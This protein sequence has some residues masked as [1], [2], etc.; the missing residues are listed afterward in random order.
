MA[1]EMKQSVP[2][3]NESKKAKKEQLRQIYLNGNK[4][5]FEVV[6]ITLFFIMW[7][8]YF[9]NVIFSRIHS[10]ADAAMSLIYFVVAMCLA[11][12]I[13]GMVHWYF[14]TWGTINTPL[15]G[16]FIRSFREHHLD[17]REICNHDFVETNADSTVGSVLLLP[18]IIYS[19][20]NEMWGLQS[21]LIWAS[22]LTGFTNE[23][24]KW[25]HE[26]RPTGII[27]FLQATHLVL[28]CKHHH[29]HHTSP[30]DE[31]YCITN[32]WLNPVLSRID[33]WRRLETFITK[34]TGAVPREDDFAWCDIKPGKKH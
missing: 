28:P 9:Y 2:D 17:A 22:L 15:L 6:V 20:P 14:D 30:H 12:W 23:F 4:R 8:I 27:K 29:V 13:S 33:Y 3:S 16:S 24:H 10:V 26:R 34:V 11:D 5:K 31:Y 7:P 32:G 25:S 1:A 21:V 18:V 19:I